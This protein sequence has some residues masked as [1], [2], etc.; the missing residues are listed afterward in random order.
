MRAAVL[1]E[2]GRPPEIAELDEPK[3]GPDWVKIA[4][5]AS[6]VNP[7]DWKIASGGL[8]AVLDTLMQQLSNIKAGL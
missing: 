4:V 3:I 6:S 1:T 2:Y 8:D 5:K 7:V